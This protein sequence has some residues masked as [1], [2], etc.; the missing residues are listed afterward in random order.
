MVSPNDEPQT[1][2]GAAAADVQIEEASEI[3]VISEEDLVK[4]QK[5]FQ[6]GK[7][8]LLLNKY[9]ES[10]NNIE[11]ACRVYSAKY[12]EF[13]PQCAE[14]YFYFGK[15]L[16]ELAR[17]ENNVLGNALSGVPEDT[18]P[19]DDSRYGN[20]DEIPEEEKEQIADKVIDA[21]CTNEEK[22]GEKA[23]TETT[24]ATSKKDEAEPMEEKKPV[25]ETKKEEVAGEGEKKETTAEKTEEKKEGEEDGDGDEDEEGDEDDEDGGD[26]DDEEETAAKEADE[27]SNLQRAWEM[28]EL[29]KLVYTK[30]VAEDEL[31]KKKRIAECLVKLG[32]ISIEQELYEQACTDIKE[33][34]RLQEEQ[35]DEDRDE[36]MLAETYYQQGLAQQFNNQFDD[37]KESFQRA[38]NIL[39]LRTEKL[40]GRLQTTGEL[41]DDEKTKLNDEIAEIE[42]LL[43][44]LNGKLEEVAEQ[45]KQ[46]MAA[47]QEAK[48]C[49]MNNVVANGGGFSPSK[50]AAAAAAA[51][52]G[53]GSGSGTSNGAEVKDITS[54][55]KSKRKIS[56]PQEDVNGL[57]KTRL[58][59]NG[60]P[61]SS[62]GETADMQTTSEATTGAAPAEIQP[63]TT[64]PAAEAQETPATAQ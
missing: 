6:Q 20:P 21:M 64:T 26:D 44:E 5:S 58:S 50:T 14:V 36:R 31:T 25:E 54:M 43:P 30:N 38:L 13:D 32:E 3:K 41:S 51:A 9:A 42:T 16:L 59:A 23:T 48:E 27:I 28:F 34:I 15:A 1:A 45:D 62:G 4:A 8:N 2:T 35:K 53:S 12:G 46:S 49:F 39:Q 37:A 33:S 56:G 24:E 22:E 10:V 17:V 11:E 18:G 19:I 29:A 55:M 40:R 60:A 52:G 7:K 63:E 57:K 61:S 47:I